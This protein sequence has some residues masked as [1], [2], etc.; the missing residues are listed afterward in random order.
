MKLVRWLH[1]EKSFVICTGLRSSARRDSVLF[2][3]TTNFSG[4][5]CCLYLQHRI[6]E[7][8]SKTLV[9]ICKNRKVSY[10]KTPFPGRLL[11]RVFQKQYLTYLGSGK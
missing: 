2:K 7:M 5:N 9:R 3:M 6:M 11:L 1:E 4:G 10:P 8:S